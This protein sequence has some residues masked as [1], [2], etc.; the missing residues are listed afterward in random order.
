MVS[1]S[2]GTLRPVTGRL[3]DWCPVF[4]NDLSVSS[5][6]VEYT[7]KKIA[8]WQDAI[9]HNNEDLINTFSSYHNT[10]N[11]SLPIRRDVMFNFERQLEVFWEAW[12]M[13]G[14]L[15]EVAQSFRCECDV[16]CYRKSS[17]RVCLVLFR[18]Q[19]GRLS[20]RRSNWRVA[21]RGRKI[22]ISKRAFGLVRITECVRRH[23]G[24]QPRIHIG[25]VIRLV[26]KEIRSFALFQNT[27]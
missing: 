4:R 16:Q 12:K 24:A 2:S 21:F 14:M 20:L 23:D 18:L 19:Y 26:T 7:M 25:E 13:Q 1:R 5:T 15:F 3:D 11:I 10:G 6:R 27:Q 22:L 17:V 8:L 9:P